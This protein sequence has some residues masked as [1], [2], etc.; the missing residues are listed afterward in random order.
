VSPSRRRLL[1]ALGAGGG[2]L[3]GCSGRFGDSSSA[4]EYALDADRIDQSLVAFA[5]YEPGDDPVFGRPARTALDAML[6]TGSY[7]TYGYEPLPEDVYVRH[8]GSYYVTQVVVT[9]RKTLTRRAV[10]LTR[11]DEDE[12]DG[13]ADA[14]QVDSLPQADARVLKILHSYEWSGGQGSASDLVDDGRYVLRRP[15]EADGRI[16]TDLDGQLVAMDEIATYRVDVVD[17]ELTEP[18]YTARAVEVATSRDAFADIAAATRVDCHLEPSDLSADARDLLE[19]VVAR[20]VYRETEPLSEPF[21][22]LRDALGLESVEDGKTGQV[23]RYDGSLYRYGLYV[24]GTD[25]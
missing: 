2:A 25:D 16:A 4:P 24:D 20:D 8:D 21:V 5:L 10:E 3:A 1:H 12:T 13:T 23:L 11:V 22:A 18:A 7:T 9:G 19:Q 17:V 6:P 14:V 15:A